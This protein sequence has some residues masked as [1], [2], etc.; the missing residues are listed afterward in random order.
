MA[1]KP[2]GRAALVTGA[3]SGIGRVIEL[4]FAEAAADVVAAAFFLALD[5]RSLPPS[6]A[7]SRS[8]RTRYKRICG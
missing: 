6:T 2:D 7:S 5:L 8:A 4:R 1:D 3:A